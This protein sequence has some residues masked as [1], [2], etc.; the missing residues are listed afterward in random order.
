MISE[1]SDPEAAEAVAA[2]WQIVL[3]M[4]PQLLNPEFSRAA[5]A[6]PRLRM[7]Y[8]LVSHGSLQFSR[9]TK[10]PWSRDIP[11]LFRRARGGFTVLRLN[12]PVGSDR[13]TV[14]ESETVEEAIRLIVENLPPGCG[15]AVT[16]TADDL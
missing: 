15:P 12:E 1:E 3:D 6:E 5:F 11:A 9:C 10:F 16:G 2:Q 4:D 13:Q 14:G 8:P 7:L